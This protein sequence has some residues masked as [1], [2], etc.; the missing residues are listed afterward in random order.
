MQEIRKN[1]MLIREILP[2]IY[3][4]SFWEHVLS[5]CRAYKEDIIAFLKNL[6][7]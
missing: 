3:S 4:L 7:A 1:K 5:W 6:T 2:F